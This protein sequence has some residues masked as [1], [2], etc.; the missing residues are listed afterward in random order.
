MNTISQ[1][2][3]LVG[4]YQSNFLSPNP[5]SS[6]KIRFS[7]ICIL[8]LIRYTVRLTLIVK[9]KTDTKSK[10]TNKRTD[11]QTDN[12]NNRQSSQII[13]IL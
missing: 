4:L 3:T 5:Q 1:L 8:N 7:N 10:Q 6:H 13:R 12:Q 11:K 2:V 9:D